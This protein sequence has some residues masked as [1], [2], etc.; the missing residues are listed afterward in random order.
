MF[1]LSLSECVVQPICAFYV[2]V[3]FTCDMYMYVKERNCIYLLVALDRQKIKEETVR[4]FQLS[5]LST[6]VSVFLL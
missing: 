2:F 1:L 5:Y 6:A 4:Y 3:T